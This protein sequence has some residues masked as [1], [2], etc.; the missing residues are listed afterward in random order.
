M[1][2]VKQRHMHTQPRKI[3]LMDGGSDVY[4]RALNGHW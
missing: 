2:G 4:T 3:R 1:K